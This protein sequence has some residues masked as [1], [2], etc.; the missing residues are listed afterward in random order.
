[1]QPVIKGNPGKR[2]QSLRGLENRAGLARSTCG[3]KKP[4]LN[5]D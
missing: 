4:A 3:W 2:M 1:M 5:F